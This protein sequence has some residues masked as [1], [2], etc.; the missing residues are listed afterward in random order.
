[1]DYVDPEIVLDIYFFSFFVQLD[2]INSVHKFNWVF[3]YASAHGLSVLLFVSGLMYDRFTVRWVEFIADWASFEYLIIEESVFLV[4]SQV[5]KIGDLWD[6]T[7]IESFGLF[8]ISGLLILFIAISLVSVLLR[9]Q[10]YIVA[11][12]SVRLFWLFNWIWTDA[13]TTVSSCELTHIQSQ[14]FLN[15]PEVI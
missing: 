12:W 14:P 5:S 11:N 2:E 1:M 15:R 3:R 10:V 7:E 8:N 13:I 4:L 9:G 6:F